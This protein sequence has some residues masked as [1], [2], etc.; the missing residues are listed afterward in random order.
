MFSIDLFV[1]YLFL[2]SCLFLL[3]LVLKLGVPVFQVLC[4]NNGIVSLAL[5]YSPRNSVIA[6]DT[7]VVS[8]SGNQQKYCFIKIFLIFVSKIGGESE[9]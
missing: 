4:F 6:E 7:A 1:C 3:L 8:P 2:R 5:I 9:Y